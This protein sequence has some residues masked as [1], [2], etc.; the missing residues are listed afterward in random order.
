MKRFTDTKKWGD[1]WFYDLKPCSKLLFIYLCEN[2]D[3][4]GVIEINP[5]KISHDTGIPLTEISLEEMGDR[6]EKLPSGRYFIKRFIKFQY[7]ELTSNSA[8]HRKII[9]LLV[10]HGLGDRCVGVGQPLPN[11]SANGQQPSKEK[12]KEEEKE[13]ENVAFDKF[14]SHYPKKTAKSAARRAFSKAIR[15][16]SVHAMIDAVER[17]KK[18]PQ[19]RDFQFIPYP[20]TWLNDERWLDESTPKPLGFMPDTTFR[21]IK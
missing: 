10:S 12:V 15:K 8:F 1:A 11:P 21:A 18:T 9:D 7:G 3:M 19:W 16:A 17:Q 4:A 14:Y 13:E 6:I 2:C 20:A 5:R